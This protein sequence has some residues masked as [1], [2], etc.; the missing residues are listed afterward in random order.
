MNLK[1]LYE[2][3]CSR[4][5]SIFLAANRCKSYFAL[6]SEEKQLTKWPHHGQIIQK[7]LTR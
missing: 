5:L 1:I 2:L 4:Y 6:T 7:D 3:V